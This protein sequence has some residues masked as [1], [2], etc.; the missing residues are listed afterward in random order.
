MAELF[1]P[2]L[3]F[4][5]N[6]DFDESVEVPFWGKRVG[7]YEDGHR[8]IIVAIDGACRG[9]GTARAKA[10]IGVYFGQGNRS[11]NKSETLPRRDATSQRAELCAALRTVRF[12]HS[13]KRDPSVDVRTYPSRLIMKTD[14]DYLVKSMTDYIFKWETNDYTNVKGTVVQNADLFRALFK[15]IRRLKR[16]KLYT[17]AFWKVPR[18]ENED[19]DRLANAALDLSTA[20]KWNY[21]LPDIRLVEAKYVSEKVWKWHARLGHLSLEELKRTVKSTNGMDVTEEQVQLEI[22]KGTRCFTC[23]PPQLMSPFIFA[24][25]AVA[26]PT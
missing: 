2:E 3:H 11:S 12:V 13:S 7:L 18:Y 24:S 9:N 14:S 20:P 8:T 23:D 22:D 6:L 26:E 15:A 21:R 19:A 25:L 4:G 1:V 17:V 16:D 10:S 5:R